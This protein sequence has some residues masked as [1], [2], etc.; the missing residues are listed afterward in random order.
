[1]DHPS[2]NLLTKRFARTVWILG[3]W[4]VGTAIG[5]GGWRLIVRSGG[6]GVVMGIVDAAG[7]ALLTAGAGIF[8]TWLAHCIWWS[9]PSQRFS[10]M[11]PALTEARRDLF[12]PRPPGYYNVGD[13]YY[14]SLNPK[15]VA[16]IRA[17][18]RKLDRQRIPH[19]GINGPVSH[20]FVYLGRL[21][22]ESK[23]GALEA[24]KALWREMQDEGM[25]SEKTKGED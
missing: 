20:W 5:A 21:I 13:R 1:M 24:A 10:R 9:M 11:E 17:V 16:S 22:G 19:P 4:V 23:A 2:Q 12:A 25:T 14:V 15:N 18:V 3:G 8:L 7:V 6:D